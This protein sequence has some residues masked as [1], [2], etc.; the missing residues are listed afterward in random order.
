MRA[1][2]RAA[3]P[4]PP[5]P[6]PMTRRT[7]STWTAPN[8][9][10]SGRTARRGACTATRP[11][12]S[13]A[14]GPCCCRRSTPRSW[15]GWP[16]TPGSETTPSAAWSAPPASSWPPCSGRPTTP[17]R[18]S[19]PCR[20]VHRHVRGQRADGEAYDAADP[21]L[22]TFVHVTEVD[23]FLAANQ[24]YGRHRLSAADADRYCAEMAEV[25]RRP[26]RRG[27]APDG[28]GDLRVAERASAGTLRL[29][30]RRPGHP[31]VPVQPTPAAGCRARPTPR[32]RSRPSGSSRCGPRS[33]CACRRCPH[34]CPGR[35]ARGQH[36]AGHLPLGLLPGPPRSLAAAAASRPVLAPPAG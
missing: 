32:W 16:S 18:P 2:V 8:P 24:A 14:S 22:V 6:E 27:R 36:P 23:S 12:S 11:R 25:A 13:G 9:G 21:D 1:L 35:P 28:G 29:G 3:D 15:P 10:C 17:R 20:R 26:R 19:P 34:R 30:T 33:G 7:W 4:G 31:P 5:G